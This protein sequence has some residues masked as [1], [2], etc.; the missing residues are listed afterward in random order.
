MLPAM[1]QSWGSL[2]PFLRDG[3]THQPV[4]A[5]SWS[6]ESSSPAHCGAVPVSEGSTGS[7][8]HRGHD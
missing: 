2:S 3:V 5:Q 6:L 7:D 4:Q 1:A 8:M